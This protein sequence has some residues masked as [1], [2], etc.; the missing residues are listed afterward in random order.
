M[1]LFW[2]I[3]LLSASACAECISIEQ[4]P[5]KIGEIVCVR[6]TVLKAFESQKSGTWFLDFCADYRTCPFT[7]VVFPR[8]LRDVGD[9][10]MLVG[11]TIEIHGKITSYNNRAEIVLKHSRQLKGE[12]AKLPPVPKTYDADRRGRYS[13]GRF[14]R[15]SSDRPRPEPSGR[16]DEEK[17]VRDPEYD[18][19]R[20]DREE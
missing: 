18:P 5:Q 9:I 16:R 11:R 1:R 14:P 13:A 12:S 3:A 6:G 4:A 8:Y 2:A 17:K 15:G 20:D 7:V 10:R 19:T